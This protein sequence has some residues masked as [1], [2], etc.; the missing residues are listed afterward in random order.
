MCFV[1]CV[2]CTD[3]VVVN[4]IIISLSVLDSVYSLT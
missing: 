2:V 4:F 1:G 3:N